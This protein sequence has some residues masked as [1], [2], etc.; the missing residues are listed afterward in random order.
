M[1][2]IDIAAAIAAQ[3]YSRKNVVTASIDDLSFITGVKKGWIVQLRARVNFTSRTSMEI[4]VRVDGEFPQTGERNHIASAYLTF[5][6]IDD[7]G[8]PTPVPQLI[9][10]GVD[11]QRRHDEATKRRQHRLSRRGKK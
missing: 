2:W 3:R 10:Q 8:K 4:G 7:D 6:A 5:V 9:P 1:S 11:G